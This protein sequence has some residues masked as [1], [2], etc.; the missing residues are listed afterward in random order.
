MH[1]SL[2]DKIVVRIERLKV[3]VAAAVPQQPSIQGYADRRG[4]EGVGS[5]HTI[6][7]T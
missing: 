6:Q 7:S 4:R 3:D 5:I 2:T 1:L